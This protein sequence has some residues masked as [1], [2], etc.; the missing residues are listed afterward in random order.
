MSDELDDDLLLEGLDDVDDD[1][2]SL[3]KFQPS[4]N[5]NNSTSYEGRAALEKASKLE[6]KI[7]EM[8][9]ATNS[10]KRVNVLSGIFEAA[11]VP[12]E[13]KKFVADIVHAQSTLSAE[14]LGQIHTYL[15]G[16]Q[17]ELT[18]FRQELTSTQNNIS[19]LGNNIAFRNLVKR[20]LE[21]HF[22]K[23]TIKEVAVDKAIELHAKLL[24]KDSAYHLQINQFVNNPNLTPKQQ[25]ALVGELIT[26]RYKNHLAKVKGKEDDPTAKIRVEKDPTTEKAKAKHE[27]TKDELPEG[28]EKPVMTDE[29]KAK[30]LAKLEAMRRRG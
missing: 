2:I 14:D 29:A 25:D 9:Q 28:E 20:H 1:E 30:M 3:E 11:D 4:L 8:L 21:K 22:R 18:S 15:Q 27:K 24:D 12:N 19:G 16:L 6:K 7:E 5:A 10:K 26:T 17:S 23:S 13:I